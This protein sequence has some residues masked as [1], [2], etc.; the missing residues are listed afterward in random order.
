MKH[1]FEK[2]TCK[3]V[4]QS[5][6]HVMSKKFDF[7]TPFQYG[8]LTLKHHENQKVTVG[9][10]TIKVHLNGRFDGDSENLKVCL[11]F[12]WSQDFFV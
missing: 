7:L 2:A 9:Q 4:I 3:A 10:N 6:N 5:T 1:E 11:R 8:P 12:I